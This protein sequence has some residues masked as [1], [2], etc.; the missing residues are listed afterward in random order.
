MPKIKKY[1]SRLIRWLKKLVSGRP[2]TKTS[3]E[4]LVSYRH[5]QPSDTPSGYTLHRSIRTLIYE[6][7]LQVIV[8]GELAPLIIS[9]TPPIDELVTAWQNI[10]EEYSEAIKSPQSR[11]V[12]DCY[13]R[14]IITQAQMQ[15]IDAGLM[16]L[17]K[18][19]DEDV[20]SV[21][22]NMGYTLIAW[23]E[24][25]EVYMNR[26]N[27]VRTEAKTLV[28]LLTQYV[29]EYKIL[30][31]DGKEVSRD[32]KSYFTELAILSKHQG[33]AIKVKEITVLEYCSIVNS[34]IAYNEALKH[35]DKK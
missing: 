33:Y 17:S 14:I 30:S 2:S 5:Q 21:I 31:P 6:D 19:F 32:Y 3:M 24:D 15:V 18:H 29:N 11:S 13:K 20:A 8:S 34:F 9:G 26:I 1:F 7:F 23:D 25:N 16:Y 27:R 4:P 12:F 10:T 35:S 22:A 28:V